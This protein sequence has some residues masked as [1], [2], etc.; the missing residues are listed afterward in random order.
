[1]LG[2]EQ[3]TI[4]DIDTRLRNV[5]IYTGTE[6]ATGTGSRDAGVVYCLF[7]VLAP[8]L[9]VL[10]VGTLYQRLRSRQH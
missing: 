3:W 2:D 6:L 10:Y 8:Y 5:L 9:S 4:S 7:Y 1:V